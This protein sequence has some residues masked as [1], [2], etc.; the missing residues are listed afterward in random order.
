MVHRVFGREK[1]ESCEFVI[2]T[3]KQ[4]LSHTWIRLTIKGKYHYGMIKE[5]DS[6][7]MF[8]ST[9]EGCQL[10]STVNTQPV[11]CKLAVKVLVCCE[12]KGQIVD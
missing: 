12:R 10:D 1:G 7:I 5:T 6:R 11:N 4:F 3:V 2:Q 8:Y 9:L